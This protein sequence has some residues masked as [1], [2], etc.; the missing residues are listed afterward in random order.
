MN[1]G[2]RARIRGK[3]A[4][5][6]GLYTKRNTKADVECRSEAATLTENSQPFEGMRAGF[7]VVRASFDPESTRGQQGESEVD[8]QS[9]LIQSNLP[10]L[11]TKRLASFHIHTTGH[12]HAKF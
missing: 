2:G 3:G 7:M 1:Y 12:H 9:N 4:E 6:N 11:I 5:E 8:M 10:S